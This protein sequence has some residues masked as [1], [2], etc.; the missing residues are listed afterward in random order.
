[1]LLSKYKLT[2]QQEK[3]EK[4]LS[5]IKNKVHYLNNILNDFLSVEKL[6]KG[7]IKYNLT[8][9]QIKRTDKRSD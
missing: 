7:E 8:S 2:E 3:R 4:H 5:I 1:M 6:E 9:F